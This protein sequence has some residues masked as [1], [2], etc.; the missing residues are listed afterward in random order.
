[1]C[2]GRAVEATRRGA[3][4][5]KS[6]VYSSTRVPSKGNRMSRFVH[7]RLVVGAPFF[8]ARVPRRAQPSSIRLSTR[9][10]TIRDPSDDSVEVD[11]DR[12]GEVDA[13]EALRAACSE[14]LKNETRKKERIEIITL[15]D[16]PAATEISPYG[17]DKVEPDDKSE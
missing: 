2:L 15:A 3:E 9:R 14:V 13:I 1:M 11:W 16:L 6:S 17:D 12:I 4:V 7:S 8:R 5:F 10:A